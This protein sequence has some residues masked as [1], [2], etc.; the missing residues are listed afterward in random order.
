MPLK[1]DLIVECSCISACGYKK[2]II[3]VTNICVYI[4]THTH[5]TTHAHAH[6]I[7]Y[8]IVIVLVR[9]YKYCIIHTL[10]I[11]VQVDSEVCEQV[12]SWLS[13]Y[14]K[15]TSKMNRHNFMFFLLYICDLHN[16]REIDKLKRGHF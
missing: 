10:V 13:R 4:N 3:H 16:R 2:E 8:S 5:N 6:V 14:K 1:Y 15:M 9:I 12:F 7:L 11:I